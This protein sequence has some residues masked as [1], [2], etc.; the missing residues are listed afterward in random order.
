MV[1][2]AFSS[3]WL[4]VGGRIASLEKNQGYWVFSPGKKE[5]FWNKN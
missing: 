1:F 5:N 2:L 3:W 4:V